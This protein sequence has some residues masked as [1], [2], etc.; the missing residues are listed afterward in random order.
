MV[1]YRPDQLQSSS[2]TQYHSH[3]VPRVMNFEIHPLTGRRSDT[4]AAEDLVDR[5]G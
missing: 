3:P 5:I 2:L 4:S 1:R